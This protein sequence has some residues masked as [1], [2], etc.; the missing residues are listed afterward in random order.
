MG[1][2]LMVFVL[3]SDWMLAGRLLGSRNAKLRQ[4]FVACAVVKNI[5]IFLGYHIFAPSHIPLGLGV[6]CLTSLGYVL[7]CYHVF[8]IW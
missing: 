1:L 4:A 2:G 6:Y 5:G 7:D 3:L 8:V